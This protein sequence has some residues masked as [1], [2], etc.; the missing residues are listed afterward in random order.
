M[1]IPMAFFL[2]I[3]KKTDFSKVTDDSILIIQKKLTPPRKVSGC[4]TQKE[5]M[6][7]GDAS[8]VVLAS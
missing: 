3:Y 5:V 6:H 7:R 4:P 2:N 8:K 1:N